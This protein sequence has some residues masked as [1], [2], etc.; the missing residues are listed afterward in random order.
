VSVNFTEAASAGSAAG[1]GAGRESAPGAASPRAGLP[2]VGRYVPV[3]RIGAGTMGEV[4]KASDPHIGRIVAVKL[5]RCPES[6][7]DAR[8]TE[9][10]RR[11]LLE[12]RAA[13]R[14]AHPGIVAIHDVGHAGDGRPF[15]VMEFV[16]GRGLDEY[17]KDDP[18]PDPALALDWAAQVADAL[19]HAHRQGIVH[20]DVK[21]A[22]ILVDR[23]GRAR[24][25][26]FGIARLADSELTRDGAFLGSP[27]YAAP[28]Q[29]RG[30]PLD[31]RADLFSLGAVTYALLTG[32][33]PFPGNDLPSLAYSICHAEPVAPS[34]LR[35]GL[36]PAI[37]AAVLKALAKDPARRCRTGSEL[38]DELRAAVASASIRATRRDSG[39]EVERTIVERTVV[40][41]APPAAAPSGPAHAEAIEHRAAELGSAAAVGC[42]RAAAAVASGSTRAGT[43]AAKTWKVW[44]PRIARGTRRATAAAGSAVGRWA[45]ACPAA[46]ARRPLAAAG[47]AFAAGGLAV[48]VLSLVSRPVPEVETSPSPTAAVRSFF[49]EAVLR[50]NVGMSV[51]HGLEEGKLTVW[52]DGGVVKNTGLAT[53]K[54]KVAVAGKKLV[55]YGRD[56]EEDTFRLPPG[57][58]TLS[59]GVTSSDGKVNLVKKLAVAIA[60]GERYQLDVSV[61]S[62]PRPKLDV[63]WRRG[64]TREAS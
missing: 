39:E 12:A 61:R 53:R 4:W 54:K 24:L 1:R 15:I 28:E 25:A 18:L 32:S 19:D 7:D 49:H 57:E 42:V 41:A 45:L 20:R 29:I 36:S 13:G 63:V 38:A 30:L 60:E 33:R 48:I 22:N 23:D 50:E 2:Q 59:I 14:L 37:E 21:P 16:E 26:D 56:T 40:D 47:I 64:A 34:H 31:G 58:H 44:A 5:L 6:F 51:S 8:R 43:R 11:F 52:S 27:A 9:W 46:V 35:S 62:W 10:E 55:S 17:L 3:E